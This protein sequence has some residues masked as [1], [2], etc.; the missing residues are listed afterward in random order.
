MAN[1]AEEPRDPKVEQLLQSLQPVPER[2]PQAAADGRARFLSQAAAQPARKLAVL[3]VSTGQVG[4]HNGWFDKFFRKE[5]PKMSVLTTLM[6]IVALVFGGSGAAYAAAQPSL[7]DQPL[8]GLKLAGED[9]QMQ[10]TANVQNRLELALKFSQRRVDEMEKMADAG[11]DIPAS[12][13]ARWQQ[14][15]QEAVH[16]ATNM[17]EEGGRTRAM[18]QVHEQLQ[19][20]AQLM[21]QAADVPLMQQTR[22]MIQQQLRQVEQIMAG[23]GPGGKPEDNPQGGN[24]SAGGN[25]WTTGTPTPGSSYGPGPGACENCTPQGSNTPQGGN[26]SSGGNPWTSDTPT[27]GSGYGPGPG[28]CDNCTPQGPAN[29]P[30]GGAGATPQGGNPS[31]GG[32]SYATG[33]PTPGSGYGPGPGTCDTC[34]P[35]GSNTPQGGNPP[36]TAGSPTPGSGKG[37]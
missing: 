28:T 37:K 13:Q 3:P 1:L 33:I 9:L 16:L 6:L 20:Q 18:L 14:Q 30:Q 12:V 11:K 36:A 7:P 21:D 17:P 35:Q 2:S 34:T 5:L 32:N 4:R 23:F 19:T 25:P 29:T 27:P 22:Q 24:P 26:P 10:L 8:Y 15:V 31:S